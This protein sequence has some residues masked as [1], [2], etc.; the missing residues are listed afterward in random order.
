MHNN[1][2]R[3]SGSGGK[4]LDLCNRDNNA[5]ESGEKDKYCILTIINTTILDLDQELVRFWNRR[6]DLDELD[7]F[8]S[9]YL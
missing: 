4:G 5:R 3:R 7:N 1:Q 2:P 9:A 6:W 8:G